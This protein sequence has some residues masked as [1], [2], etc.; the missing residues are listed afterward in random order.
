MT[1]SAPSVGIVANP[2]SGRDIRRLVSHASAFATVEKAN[3]AQRVLSALGALGIERALMMPDGSGICSGVLRARE[4]LL[5]S[6]WI[7]WPRLEILDMPLE[8]GAADT[9]AAVERMS[10]QGVSAIVVLGGDGTHR[11]VAARCGA[12]PLATLSTGTNN[13]FPDLGEATVVGMA[14]A[15]VARGS[16]PRDVSLRRNKLLRV[17]P[18][19]GGRAAE[20]A[21]VDVCVS[22]L[23]AVGARALW[24]P[25]TLSELAVSF[26]EADAIG[27]SAIAGMLQPVARDQ[28]QGLYVQLTAP[29]STGAQTTVTAAIAPGLVAEVGVAS[30]EPLLPQRGIV[31][32]TAGG[33]IALDGEREIGFSQGE[34]FSVTLDPAGPYT[35]D[36]SRTLAWAAQNGALRVDGDAC[37]APGPERP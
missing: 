2:A 7:R 37:P 1:D 23:S 36:V 5:A 20:I 17:A 27:L 4:R 19:A 14:A 28:A 11:A 30:V 12:V 32:R 35:I 10:A 31:L 21:L 22:S 29:R 18:L 3:M 9:L 15:L 8:G 6:H 26:A 25:D 33:T 16:V 34:R 24:R 13:V